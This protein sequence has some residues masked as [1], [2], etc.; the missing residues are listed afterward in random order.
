MQATWLIQR[1]KA[2][3]CGRFPR[4]PRPYVSQQFSHYN[5]EK[6]KTIAQL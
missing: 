6:K 3:L 4:I 5:I 2:M 1:Y